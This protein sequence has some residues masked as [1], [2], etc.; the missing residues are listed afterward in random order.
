MSSSRCYPSAESCT[1][2]VD[3]DANQ[4]IVIWL[5]LILSGYYVVE[6]F[7]L[8]Y[9]LQAFF[10]TLTASL[11]PYGDW[12][13]DATSLDRLNITIANIATSMTNSV[14]QLNIGGPATGTV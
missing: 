9:V 12:S 8:S 3:G 4:L 14:R 13:I 6:T 5:P 7:F 10:I 2:T 1:F 11:A